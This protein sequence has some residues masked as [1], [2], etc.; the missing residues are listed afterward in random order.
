MKIQFFNFLG[1]IEKCQDGRTLLR[2]L[3]L[4][5]KSKPGMEKIAAKGNPFFYQRYQ[6]VFESGPEGSN[7]SYE[8]EKYLFR[9]HNELGNKWAIISRKMNGR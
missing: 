8:E 7:W 3:P 4:N 5:S 2:H 6:E 9:L 1:N